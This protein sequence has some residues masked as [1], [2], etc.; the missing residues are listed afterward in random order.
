MSRNILIIKLGAI[1]DIVMTLPLVT[2]IK[3]AEPDASI[4]WVC[5]KTVASILQTVSEIDRL[6]IVDERIILTGYFFPRLREIFKLWIALSGKVYDQIINAYQDRRYKFLTL[7]LRYKKYSSFMGD[8]PE[9][10]LRKERYFGLEFVRLYSAEASTD[11]LLSYPVLNLPKNT[12]LLSSVD[13]KK[14]KNVIIA[15]GGAKNVLNTDD[16]RRWDIASYVALAQEL[17]SQGY[18]I[19]LTGAQHDGWVSKAFENVPV[20]NLIGKTN[21]IDLLVLL[22]KVNLLITHDTGILHLAKLTKTR[23]IGLYGPVNPRSFVGKFDPVTVIWMPK[24]LTCAPCY[25]GKKFADCTN[26]Q[27]LKNITIKDVLDKILP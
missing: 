17:I 9:N 13:I 12:P 15:A 3:R 26:N 10:T 22:S 4:T 23:T 1:G 14:S 24:E 5:G 25:D 7:P 11:E 6:I 21:L 2:A 20:C 8:T 19:I 16:L 27:C 18:N